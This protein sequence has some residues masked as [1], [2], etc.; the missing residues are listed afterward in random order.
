M[1]NFVPMNMIPFIANMKR[2]SD[3]GGNKPQP[4]PTPFNPTELLNK[5]V[6]LDFGNTEKFPAIGENTYRLV[7]LE[8]EQFMMLKE[9][10]NIY[11][12]N[13][14]SF[15]INVEDREYIVISYES[16]SDT[17]IG[18][19]VDIYID[20]VSATEHNTFDTIELYTDA[21]TGDQTPIIIKK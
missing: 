6:T 21:E 14:P 13:I 3:D 7:D 10:C 11:S 16:V 20:D 9:M 18:D 8:P 19:L 12:P 5:V 15:K 2:V 1:N 4:S 17:A